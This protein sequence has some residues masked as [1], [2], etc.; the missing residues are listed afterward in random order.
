MTADLATRIAAICVQPRRPRR[1]GA[2][3]TF[4]MS[5]SRSRAASRRVADRGGQ[6]V[7]GEA[8]SWMRRIDVVLGPAV[9]ADRQAGGQVTT[10]RLAWSS[11]DRGSSASAPSAASTRRSSSPPLIPAR[12]RLVSGS[13]CRAE[14]PMSRHDLLALSLRQ[15]ARDG[16]GQHVRGAA[17]VEQLVRPDRADADGRHRMI[18]SGHRQDRASGAG[19]RHRRAAGTRPGSVG[20]PFLGENPAGSPAAARACGQEAGALVDETG[21]GRQRRLAH[22]VAAQGE[23]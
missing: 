18:V 2:V 9:A 1:A 11:A 5:V 8:A 16:A 17:G 22:Q 12:S 6:I 3:A 19:R 15:R 14:R 4:S 20:L 13:T 21:P 23:D 7:A 10:L